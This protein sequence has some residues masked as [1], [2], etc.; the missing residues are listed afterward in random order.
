MLRTLAEK[1]SAKNAA[2]ITIDVQNDFCSPEAPP[3]KNFG[4]DVTMHVAMIDA[5][6]TL[7][8][9][10]RQQGLPIVHVRTE[11]PAWAVSDAT[12]ELRLRHKQRRAEGVP[13]M[14]YQL[15]QPGSFGAEFYRLNP[16]KDD[17]VVVKHRYSAFF[18]TNLEVI[19]GSLNRQ[20]LIFCGGGTNMCLES[21]VRDAFMRDFYCVVVRDCAPTPWGEAAYKASLANMELGFAE[22]ATLEQVA[23]AWGIK[24][25]APLSRSTA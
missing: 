9:F 17:I 23:A 18:S 22:L 24:K 2:L 15:C 4:R 8:H 25:T 6:L 11:E 16:E 7:V 5:L 19:L 3:A 1:V 14:D 12:R 21:S 13:N 10:A 20:S